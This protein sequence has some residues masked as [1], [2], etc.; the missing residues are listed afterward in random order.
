MESRGSSG[1]PFIYLE[2]VENPTQESDS[3][4]DNH[5]AQKILLVPPLSM[6]VP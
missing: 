3:E 2:C 1:D 5:A 6:R 4:S